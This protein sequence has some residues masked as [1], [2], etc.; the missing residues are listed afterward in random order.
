ML[1][2]E[3]HVEDNIFVSTRTSY[4]SDKKP[5]PYLPNL[6]IFGPAIVCVWIAG[7][8][9]V[10][11][12]AW[13]LR[14]GENARQAATMSSAINGM[15][16]R[17]VRLNIGLPSFFLQRGRP[18]RVLTPTMVRVRGRR[19]RPLPTSSSTPAPTV[20]A[21]LDGQR[22]SAAWRLSNRGTDA[23]CCPVGLRA[24]MPCPVR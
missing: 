3:V 4:T 23:G 10:I 8:L 22:W 2:K 24:S 11:D 16:Q 18:R 17:S 15:S 13:L 21:N 9:G 7:A 6:I 5:L 12:A 1:I 14:M 19:K 20:I